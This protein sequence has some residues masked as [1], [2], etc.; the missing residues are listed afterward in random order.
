MNADISN[1]GI[2]APKEISPWRQRALLWIIVASLGAILLFWEGLISLGAAWSRPEYSYGPLVPL[3]TGYLTLLEIHRH[4]LKPDYGSR[5]LGL[6]VFVLS[7]LVGLIGNLSEI[8]DIITYGFILYIGAL[9]LLLAGTR[10]GFRFWPGWLH[11]IFML[12]L[13]QFIYLNVSTFLQEISSQLGVF[14]IQLVNIP[15]FLD[16]NVIDLGNYKLLV[17]EACS[18]LRYLFPL[19]SFGWLM[20]VLYNG[21]NW[22]RVVIFFSTIPITIVMNSFRIGMIGVL[23]NHYGIAQAEGFLHFFEG[24]VI[25]ITCTLLLYLEALLLSRFFLFGRPQPSYVIGMDLQGILGPL[26]MFPAVTAGRA[27]VAAAALT[28]VAGSLWQVLPSHAPSPVSR[29]PL[30]VFPLQVGDWSGRASILDRKVEKVLGADDYLLAD[31]KMGDKDVNLLMT[32][33]NS[34]TQGSGIHSPEVCLP[35]GGWEV[36]RWRQKSL[37]VVEKGQ[38]IVLPVNR[39]I[40]Q[41]GLERQLVYFWFEQRG[42]RMTND[43][44]AKFVSMWDTVTEGRS[45]GGLVRLVTPINRAESSEQADERLQSFL[46]RILPQLPEYFPGI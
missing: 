38:R 37:T 17:A 8:P 46:L 24:W 43:F 4:P 32:F 29:L 15:V 7:L 21:P 25:F 6:A 33:Y 27:F 35:G 20:A 31:Y 2:V 18:G 12:P 19:F 3:I 45:D 44:E 11:L 28:L 9:I 34:Q 26:R 40:I 41:K 22:H 36:S 42:R 13:P 14:F 5:A 1:V 23:V 30:G 39:A 16:G 10:Q